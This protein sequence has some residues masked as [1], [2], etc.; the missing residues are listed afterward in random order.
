MSE[1]AP[2][3]RLLVEDEE[4]PRLGRELTVIGRPLDRR[5]ALDKVTGR[6]VYSSDLSRPGMLHAKI[7]RSPHPHAR[8][9]RVDASRA[10]ALP[11]VH[12]VLTSDD[13]PGWCT[14]WY[15]I[16]QPAF[17]PEVAY[18]GQEVA[19]VAAETPDLA[20]EALAL[21]EVDY[22]VLP[23]VF[24]PREAM[25]PGAPLV[26]ILD[27]Q[28]TREGNVQKPEYLRQSGDLERGFAEADVVVERVYE[29]PTQFH[30]DIQTRCCVADWDGQR[31]TVYEASQGVW[32]V[33]L[34]LAKSLG[35]ADDQVRVIVQTMGGGFGSKA[36]AQ[37]FVHYAARLA[38]LTGRP[39]KLELTRPE[40]FVSH[41]RRYGSEISI[42]LGARRDG[43]L[44]ALDAHV[45]LD[46]GCGSM[47]VAPAKMTLHQLSELY[48][49]PHE[50]VRIVAVYTNTSPTGPLRGVM[51]PIAVFPME[52]AMDD[53]AVR[54]G[55][56]PLAL[57][58]R[59]VRRWPDEGGGVGYSTRHVHHA[60]TTVAEAVGWP[61]RDARRAAST[62]GR[63]RRGVGIAT[64]CQERSGL[65]PYT[66]RADVVVGDDGTVE[67]RAG[68]VEIGAGQSTVLPM[69]AAEELGVDPQ[70]VRMHCGDTD[71]TQYAPSRHSS[72]VTFEVGL[73]TLQAASRA[74]RRL[75]ELV[76]PR[77]EVSPH[78]L[79][80]SR[81]RIFVRGVERHGVSF[82]EACALIPDGA[83]RTSGSRALNPAGVLFRTFGAHAV[84]VEV[85]VETGAVRVLRVVTA[86]DVGRAINPKLVE[87]Q[88]HGCIVMGLG[89]GL[90]EEAEF[91]GKTGILLNADVHQYR[92][93]T[94][95][96]T[97]AIETRNFERDNPYYPYSAKPVG[98]APLI[99]VMPAVRNAV[100]HALGV[101]LDRLPLTPAR[102]LEA[103]AD[104]ARPT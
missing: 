59:N 93:P 37:R 78:D 72:R 58:L 34:Q 85:D 74:R 55:L 87:S 13:A 52:C 23:A 73:A 33:K 98:E 41:P 16:P 95:L 79:V 7:L 69:I 39:V 31:L 81:D 66:S 26:P 96:E 1:G 82:A 40:E 64:Y 67:L 12:A 42:R 30:V 57:R 25:K 100:G 48:D 19:A 97:P 50:R 38:M 17:A 46:L 94:V 86:H 104:E 27:V 91:D 62:S 92:I 14:Y 101:R 6:A 11:G 28:Q 65:P 24:T 88:Q 4:P 20:R 35:L 89:Y 63:T 77:L 90:Y 83:I 9:R 53:L 75:F 36:G 5:D 54:L 51:D 32:N 71:G 21:I 22:E 68:V 45:L 47:F 61:A 76:A 102:I 44:T 29:M 56:D 84:E 49:C 2:G 8:I 18:A 80:S 15:M 10:R 3:P 103:L 99:G 70:R 43:R 60:L